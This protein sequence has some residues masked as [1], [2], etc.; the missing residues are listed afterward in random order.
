MDIDDE[1]RTCHE[2]V[3]HFEPNAAMDDGWMSKD[4]GGGGS[5]LKYY[6]TEIWDGKDA[7]EEVVLGEQQ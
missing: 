4:M 1:E 5:S 3:H 6:E 7:E 2:V